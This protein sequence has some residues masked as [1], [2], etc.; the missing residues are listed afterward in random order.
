MDNEL[1]GLPQVTQRLGT[2]LK[3]L[4]Q[5]LKGKEGRIRYSWESVWTFQRGLLLLPILI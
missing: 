5:R 1:W 4:Q 3:T 2:P